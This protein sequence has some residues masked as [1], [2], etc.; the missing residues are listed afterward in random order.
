MVDAGFISATPPSEPCAEPLGIVQRALEAGGALLR[1]LHQ[2]GAA[3][4]VDP[5]AGTVDVYTTLDVHLQR[6]A[7]DALRDGITRLDEILARRKR[8]P[9][10]AL[11]AVDPR[12]GEVLAFVGG[13]SYNQSQYNRA[14]SV[15]GGSRARCS[16]RSCISRRSSTRRPRAAPTSPRRRSSSTSRR[17]SCSTRRPGPRATT[18][19][20]TTVR[21]RCAGARAVAQHRR[22]EAGRVGRIRG[23]RRALAQGRR[24][25]PAAALSRDRARRVRGDA[26][27]DRHGLHLVSQRRHDPA[28]DRHLAAGGQGQ[29]SP[30]AGR[31]ATDGRRRPARPSWSPT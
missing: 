18:R 27:R 23:S 6:V 12:T 4:Q 21:S 28:A 25:H 1:R 29:G 9:Q 8:R 7:Q 11:I 3:G 10:A 17:R 14:V 20:S 30:A 5:S 2:P 16:S 22:G 31:E 15:R 26:V 13:R 24:R 19:A